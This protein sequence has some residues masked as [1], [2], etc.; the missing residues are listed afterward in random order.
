M[1]YEPKALDWIICREFSG[2]VIVVLDYAAGDHPDS[3]IRNELPAREWVTE[4]GSRWSGIQSDGTATNPPV[5]S[6]KHGA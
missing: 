2:P 3:P 5:T 6:W 4:S 1:T